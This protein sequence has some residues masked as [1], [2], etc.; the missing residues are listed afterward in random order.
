MSRLRRGVHVEAGF[1]LIEVLVSVSLMSVVM[2]IAGGSIVNAMQAQRKQVERTDTVN[3]MTIAFERVSTELRG[4]DPVQNASGTTVTAV[5]PQANQTTTTT[6]TLVSVGAGLHR[7]DATTTVQDTV[8]G[9]TTST[10]VLLDRLT[11]NAGNGIFT[12]F[13][14]AG[15]TLAA[16]IVE[17]QVHRVRMRLVVD[18]PELTDTIDISNDIVVRNAG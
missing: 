7:L 3:D 2:A 5:V 4:A 8:A 12:Y 13:D 14:A 9:T 18:L 17:S 10:R 6:F 15:A 1:S 11:D 16:P